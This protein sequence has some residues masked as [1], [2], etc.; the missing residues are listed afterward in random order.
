MTPAQKATAVLE[1]AKIIAS[2][3]SIID[4]FDADLR[5][6]AAK[7]FKKLADAIDHGPT[8]PGP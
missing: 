8:P 5:L 7:A 6:L 1:F 4:A 2:V 3:A